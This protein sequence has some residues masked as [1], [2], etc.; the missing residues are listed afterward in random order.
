MTQRE[1]P[2]HRLYVTMG[3]EVVRKS[4]GRYVIYY[5]WPEGAAGGS[6]PAAPPQPPAR[7]WSPETQPLDEADDEQA[8]DDA[9]G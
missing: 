5:T 9:D 3:T 1:R 7:P 4:D 8:R 2:R 6:G